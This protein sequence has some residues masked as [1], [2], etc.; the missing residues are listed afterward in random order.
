MRNKVAD[1]L[2]KIHDH[3]EFSVVR[4]FFEISALAVRNAVDKGNG[5][6]EREKRYLSVVN[7]YKKEQVQVFVEALAEY[8]TQINLAIEGSRPFSDFAGE[9]YMA[10]GTNSK[11]AGQFFTPY[12]VS[13]CMAE[14]NLD[15]NMMKL[16]IERNPDRVFTMMEP[17]C[18]AAGMIVAACD[19]LAIN[20]INYSWNFLADCGDIDSRCVHMSYL[21]LSLLG[22]PAIVRK[23]DALMMNYSETWLTPAYIFAWPHFKNCRKETEKTTEPANV[24]MPEPIMEKSG[25]YSLF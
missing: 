24:P 6:E 1:I 4:D 15:I 9:I 17:T 3:D 18:G 16:E 22:V 5:F 21:T 13:R 7:N 2:S 14:I 11:G 20:G 12:S 10:S 19:V 8:E 25:Q 23:G